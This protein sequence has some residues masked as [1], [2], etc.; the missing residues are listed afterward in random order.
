VT[1]VT[2]ALDALPLAA[3]LSL[4]VLLG[5]CAG[6]FIATLVLRWGAG[7]SVLG[8]SACDGCG[9]TLG[10]LDLVPVAGWLLRRGRCAACGGRIDPL[11]LRV[12]LGGA[13]IGAAAWLLMPGSGGFALALFGWMLLPLALLDARHYWLPDALVAPLALAGLLLG[14]WV[15]GIPL[16]DRLVGAVAAGGVL[17]AL[18]ALFQRLR[19]HAAMGGGDPKMAAAIGAWLGWMPLPIMFLLASGGGILWALVGAKKNV[20]IT[21]RHIPFGTFMAGAAWLALPLWALISGR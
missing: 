21:D 13:A 12:E 1:P 18:A 16:P 3:G 9:R 11:H 20:P 5:L 2:D 6:S 8:R 17:A 15:S 4:Q 7:R 14:G 19:G 10:A